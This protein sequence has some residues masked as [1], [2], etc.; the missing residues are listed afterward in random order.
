MDM[1]LLSQKKQKHQKDF[2]SYWTEV[3]LKV[4][5]SVMF[6]YKYSPRHKIRSIILTDLFTIKSKNKQTKKPM[7][8]N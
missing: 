5:V 6:H 2:C 4:N 1:Q 8:W 3:E 7:C